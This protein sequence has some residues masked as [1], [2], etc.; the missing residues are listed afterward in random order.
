M[1]SRLQDKERRREAGE[2][3]EPQRAV[4]PRRRR[5]RPGLVYVGV[6]AVVVAAIAAA[7]VSDGGGGSK[8]TQT[9]I[10]AGTSGAFGQHYAGLAQRRQ[11]AHVPTMMDTMNSRVHFHP[12]LR[13]YV[14]GKQIPVPANIGIDPTQEAMQMAGLH[15]HDTSGTIHVEGVAGAR[16]GQFF[17]IWGVPL[18]SRQLGPY[19][20]RGADG[21]RMWV[22]GK[23]STAFGQLA[24]A[25]GQHIVVSF[26]PKSALRPVG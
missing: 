23:P 25:D 15:T 7:I 16:L 6:G 2:T 22:D 3:Q 13:V 10:A 1:S 5:V 21:V 8:S 14:N 4:A 20:A 19:R 11:A 9:T 26:G 24:L 18:S 12:L 17:R